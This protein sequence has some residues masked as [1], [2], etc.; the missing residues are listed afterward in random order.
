L[1]VLGE[2]L[3]RDT[4]Q[5]NEI[6]L[7]VKKDERRKGAHAVGSL[8]FSALRNAHLHTLRHGQGE[9]TRQRRSIPG[10]AK[11]FE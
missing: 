3:M 7:C 8:N 11:S 4:P 2:V 10:P 9:A 1:E 5:M 6:L